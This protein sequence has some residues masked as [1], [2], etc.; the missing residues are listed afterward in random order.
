MHTPSLPL[1]HTHAQITFQ[2][3]AVEVV[4]A[5][6][7]LPKLTLP[8]LTD[9]LPDFLRPSKASRSVQK[10]PENS[11]AR[12]LVKWFLGQCCVCVSVCVCVCARARASLY[13]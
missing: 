9:L 7:D 1:S 6:I 5:P 3:T 2:D 11:N 8:Q 4:N 13:V 12:C 10:N